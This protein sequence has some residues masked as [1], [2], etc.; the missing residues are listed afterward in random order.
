MK[1]FYFYD[2]SFRPLRDHMF[3]SARDE[4]EVRED[5]LEDLSVMKNR[6]GGGLPTY[7]YKAQKIKDALDAVEEGEVFL[8]TDV[9]IQFF[10]PVQSIVEASM[11]DADL[12]MQREFEDDGEVDR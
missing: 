3:A 6:A 4:F 2:S 10:R 8:F 5:F 1:W 9:D 12:V 7:L 11:A